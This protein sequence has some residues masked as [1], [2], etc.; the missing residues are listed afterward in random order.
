MSIVASCFGRRCV[1]RWKRT[2]SCRQGAEEHHIFTVL[3]TWIEKRAS[4]ARPFGD[5]IVAVCRPVPKVLRR[6]HPEQILSLL[7]IILQSYAKQ[8]SA[9]INDVCCR[10]KLAGLVQARHHRCEGEESPLRRGLAI[11][12]ERRIATRHCSTS[13]PRCKSTASQVDYMFLLSFID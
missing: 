6:I 1:G 4:F 10:A 5:L 12:L 9:I 13:V 11:S 2:Q 7:H 3:T 8:P